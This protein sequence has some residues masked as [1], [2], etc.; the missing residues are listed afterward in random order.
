MK[1]IKGRV[2]VHVHVRGESG[3]VSGSRS[4][5]VSVS[6]FVSVSTSVSISYPHLPLDHVNKGNSLRRNSSTSVYYLT[7][8]PK[9]TFASH[10]SDLSLN[11][12]QVDLSLIHTQV[13]LNLR[14]DSAWHVC[15]LKR[16]LTARLFLTSASL[17]GR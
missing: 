7:I 5:F 11:H 13:D 14:R 10:K 3:S 4:V 2:R 9:C 6:M 15:L 1:K 8:A 12:T 16:S 17:Q